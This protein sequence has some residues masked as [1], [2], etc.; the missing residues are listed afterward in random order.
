MDSLEQA[1]NDGERL[2]AFLADPA[3]VDAMTRLEAL[4]VAKWK[5]SPS[6][7]EREA[8]H[9]KA[10]AFDDLRNEI[11]AIVDNGTRAKE[12]LARRERAT[13]QRGRTGNS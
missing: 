13:N 5:T 7:A 11:R 8:L 2:A 9:A 10:C 4:Y 12:D 1:I 3:L 6:V